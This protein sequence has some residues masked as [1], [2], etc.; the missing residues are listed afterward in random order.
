MRTG[1]LVT[2]RERLAFSPPTMFSSTRR[3]DERYPQVLSVDLYMKQN[4]S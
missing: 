3:L 4:R 1:G 2:I